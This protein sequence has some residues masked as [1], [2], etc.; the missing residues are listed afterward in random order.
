[1]DN[2]NSRCFT[3]P[4]TATALINEKWLYTYWS[5]KSSV[6]IASPYQF[7]AGDIMKLVSI[8]KEKRII[9]IDKIDKLEFESEIG[10]KLGSILLISN[11]IPLDENDNYR[12]WFYGC[13][14]LMQLESIDQGNKVFTF[15]VAI[16]EENA[17]INAYCRETNAKLNFQ[18]FDKEVINGQ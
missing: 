15:V 12:F 3:I 17:C 7:I 2:L 8:D 18:I 1:V 4:Y 5:L 13:E 11:D 16:T 6:I 9:N 10:I 14:L